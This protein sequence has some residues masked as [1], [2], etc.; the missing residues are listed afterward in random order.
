[1]RAATLDEAIAA[2]N[3]SPFGNSAS[4]FTADGAAVRAFRSRVQAGM[5]GVNLGVPAPFAAFSFGG[6]KVRRLSSSAVT[7]E[8]RGRVM[9]LFGPLTFLVTIYDS[10]ECL[11]Y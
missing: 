7:R 9:F 6:W 1:M 8:A 10:H 4:I 11:G 2:A 5:L 3:A